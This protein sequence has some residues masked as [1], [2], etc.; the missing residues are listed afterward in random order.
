MPAKRHVLADDF[1][2]DRLPPVARRPLREVLWVEL[3]I[4][5]AMSQFVLGA[6]LGYGM[7]FWK[8][9]W[10]LL[11]GGTLLIL[12][13]VGIGV[14]G[15]WE[16]LPTGVL[17]R[18]SGFGKYGASLISLLVVLGCTAWFG[19]QNSIFADAV[20][21][22]THG[23]LSSAPASVLTGLLTAGIASFGFRWISRTASFT[24]PAFAVLVVYGA[25]R[26]LVATP[27]AD[28]VHMG[29]PGPEI[30]LVKGATMVAGGFMLGAIL[31]ADIT[32][33]CGS[34][35]DV[36]WITVLGQVVGQFGI[37]LAGVLLAHA[38]RSRD[39]VRIT[40]DVA[41]W[42]GVG[43]ACLATVKLN[44]MN[45][46]SSSLHLTNL[47]EAIFRWRV[48]RGGLTL[49][50]GLV[51]SLFSI[52]GVL[53]HIVPFLL[54]LG[55]IVPP[56]GGVILADYF[57][58]RR[59]RQEL[60]ATRGAATLPASC[61]LLNPIAILAWLAGSLL[62]YWIPGGIASLNSTLASGLLYLAAMK[63]VGRW[64]KRP[65]VRFAR[66]ASVTLEPGGRP[67]EAE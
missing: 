8:A 24:V 65:T 48:N 21:R 14:A 5:T 17:A 37:G 25:G 28:L 38:A 63:L 61:E 32:R 35:R 13:G 15:A 41:G 11:F 57:L 6:A 16:G 50:L 33:F 52:L 40:F 12:V 34:A 55:I 27:L 18:W 43:V 44:D 53:D 31:S 46:Y 54:I 29:P 36:L 9:F 19:V 51:G 49:V 10:A 4:V 39:V 45:L 1:A 58:L 20:A 56:V 66:V 30:S 23:R 22:A 64:R 26:V 62:G 60:A 2:V 7:G 47:L 3:G 42:L 67:N 59:D